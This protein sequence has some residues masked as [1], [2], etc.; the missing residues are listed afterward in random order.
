MPGGRFRDLPGLHKKSDA[1]KRRRKSISGYIRNAWGRA[2]TATVLI[3]S[4]TCV[5]FSDAAGEFGAKGI[6][7][8]RVARLIILG[9]LT[10]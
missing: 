2:E 4:W 5:Y 6:Q 3:N 1:N 10:T 7:A 9:F 8:T